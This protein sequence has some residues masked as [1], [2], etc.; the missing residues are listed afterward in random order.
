MRRLS[1]GTTAASDNWTCSFVRKGR[2]VLDW[3]DTGSPTGFL[4]IDSTPA[5]FARTD[6]RPGNQCRS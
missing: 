2:V 5:F 6:H 3:S 4:L 1:I